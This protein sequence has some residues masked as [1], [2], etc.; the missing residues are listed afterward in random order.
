VKCPKENFSIRSEFTE[1]FPSEG[2]F[3]GEGECSERLSVRMKFLGGS[4]SGKGLFQMRKT[5]F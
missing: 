5:L 4:F 3:L 2:N 1:G